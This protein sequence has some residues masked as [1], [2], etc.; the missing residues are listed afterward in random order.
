MITPSQPRRYDGD[1]CAPVPLLDGCDP[2]LRWQP[3]KF[4]LSCDRPVEGAAASGGIGG[5]APGHTL[6][7]CCVMQWIPPPRAKI[8]RASTISTF[9]SGSSFARISAACSSRGSSNPHSSVKP[10]AR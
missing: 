1:L 9:R 4:C 3:C 7:C 10:L 6:G 2:Q 8:G 5:N